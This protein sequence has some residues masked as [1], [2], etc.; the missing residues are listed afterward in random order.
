MDDRYELHVTEWGKGDQV[1]LV[2]GGTPGGGSVAFAA[3]KVLEDHW[4]L[5]LP[6]RPGHGESPRQ[7]REDFERD[8]N[9]L[10]PLLR[11][12]SHLVGHS[13]GGVVAL[14]MAEHSPDAV[15]SLTLIEPPA[16][17]FATGDPAVAAMATANRELFEHPPES[18][19]DMMRTF[20]ALVGIDMQIPDPAP[21]P[22]LPIAE[23]FARD[24]GDI[25]GPDEASIDVDVLNTGGFPVQILTSGRIAGFEGIADAIAAQTSGHHIVV[26]GTDHTVQNAG[27]RV[28][29]LLES[30]WSAAE[31][32]EKEIKSG[33]DSQ[34]EKEGA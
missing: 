28:N 16:F 9:L 21:E 31:E 12:R 33:N 2:H 32:D 27:D 3:Q 8:A 25:R 23:A 1:V 22:F 17:C 18:P 14:C 6:D 19:V 5:V 4:H 26:S 29:P 7:G 34:N 30:F 10:G 13:Y 20:F 24:L 11:G 15:K